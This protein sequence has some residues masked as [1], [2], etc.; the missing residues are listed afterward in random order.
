MYVIEHMY[1]NS[2]IDMGILRRVYAK[3][4]IKLFYRELV[5]SGQR[6]LR[7]EDLKKVF[8]QKFEKYQLEV[9]INTFMQKHRKIVVWY[10]FSAENTFKTQ[11]W[12]FVGGWQRDF[13]MFRD[14]LRINDC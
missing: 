12:G 14:I 10:P 1:K 3:R 8:E 7:T 5:L 2:E 13:S 9:A 6:M 11:K 4:Y